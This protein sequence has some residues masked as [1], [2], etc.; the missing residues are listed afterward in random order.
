MSSFPDAPAEKGYGTK[1]L[2]P[3]E[4]ALGQ[5]SEEIRKLMKRMETLSIRVESVAAAESQDDE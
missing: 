4:A 2:K 3:L 5:R 1:Q